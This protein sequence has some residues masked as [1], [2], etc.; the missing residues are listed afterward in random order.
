MRA[1]P[2][3]LLDELHGRFLRGSL[4]T[5]AEHPA[6]NFAVQAFLAALDRPQQA[7]AQCPHPR[8]TCHPQPPEADKRPSWYCAVQ[9]M[10]LLPSQLLWR[11]A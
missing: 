11:T 7:R 5:L 8:P 6:A 3:E 2:P 1:V 9:S 4:A 10:K